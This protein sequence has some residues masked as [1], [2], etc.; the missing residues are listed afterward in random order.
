MIV[1]YEEHLLDLKGKNSTVDVGMAVAD[2]NQEPME[3]QKESLGLDIFIR[4]GAKG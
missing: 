1:H 2:L 3:R 4:G